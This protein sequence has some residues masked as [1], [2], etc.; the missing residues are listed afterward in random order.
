MRSIFLIV[1][2][3]VETASAG[4]EHREAGG[5]S[6]AVGGAVSGLTGDVYAVGYNAGAL[7]VITANEIS[8]FYE[9]GSYGIP[10][11]SYRG[12]VGAI[13]ASFGVIGLKASRFGFDL[14]RES[15]FR[16]AFARDVGDLGIGLS[17][18]W[19]SV[20]IENYGSGGALG[21]DA[22][23]MIPVSDALTSGIALRNIN[24]PAAG[25]SGEELPQSFSLG[26]AYA[27]FESMKLLLDYGKETG[28]DASPKIGF[29]Y[30]LD[31]SISL[32][33]GA[34]D[35]PSLTTMG[36]GVRFSALEF[37]YA[38]SS[39]PDLG[40]SHQASLTIRW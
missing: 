17:I 29:E 3:V 13:P 19:Y 37:D 30:R 12:A 36:V 16:I 31:E 33:A 18:S 2:A 23:L 38:L 27:P 15:E 4:F 25:P 26:I 14:Y 11:L 8:F 9:P 22:G 24:A 6:R 28:F 5:R 32:R 1:L 35:A 39:H 21:I 7:A 40:W 10:E 34:S 20:A